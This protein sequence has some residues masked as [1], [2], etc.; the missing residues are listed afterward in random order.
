MQ[1]TLNYIQQNK[2]RFVDELFDLL[3]IASIS[4][5]PAYSAEVL[6]CADELA[7]HL[8]NAGAD[9]VEVCKTDGYPIVYGEKIISADL[10]TVLVYG[11][12]DVQPPDPLDLWRKPP[13]EPYIEKTALHPDGAIFARRAADDKGQFFMHVKAFEAMMKTNSLAC[14]VK[15][16]IE[17]QEE[18][19]AKS[20]EAFVKQHTE[21]RS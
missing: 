16:L 17:G 5:D 21:K 9:K 11:H 4:A 19:G 20:L 1:E 13:F 14:N 3:K 7:K 12:Y 10:P 2:Q 15:F 18:V 6:R 8:T